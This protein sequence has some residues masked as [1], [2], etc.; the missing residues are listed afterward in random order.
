MVSYL[1]PLRLSALA[2]GAF[3]ALTACGAA[4]GSGEDD[5]G[6]A[7]DEAELRAL[8]PTEIVGPITP[9][10]TETVVHSGAPTYRGF[11]FS[12]KAG[13]NVEFW[14][15]SADGDA[16]A[17]LLRP[18]GSTL[19]RNDDASSNT[20]DA[21]LV[22]KIA[23]AGTYVLAF[24]EVKSRP[25]TF[26]VSFTG[27]APPPPPAAAAT[28]GNGI[29]EAGEICDDGNRN[30]QDGCT[31]YPALSDNE[32]GFER[33]TIA[34]A[35]EL[36]E[37]R[38]AS[39]KLY[40]SPAGADRD[41][42]TFTLSRRTKVRIDLIGESG[43]L[44]ID[45]SPSAPQMAE[46]T[47]TKIYDGQNNVIASNPYTQVNGYIHPEPDYTLDLDAGHYT[48]EIDPIYHCGNWGGGYYRLMVER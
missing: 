39:G 42:Y 24:R 21:H 9:G 6:V 34:A 10:A 40:E 35:T 41:Y 18:S 19:L 28:C 1:R 30:M 48:V 31:C 15:K 5:E 16:L 32:I 37:A 27:A 4:G 45:C 25:A 23:T 22:A 29:V 46:S 17:Y 33:T 12:A 43:H 7:I 44:S 47:M 38:L 2:L 26:T 36:G 20:S 11:T 14:V 13:D 8:K 3:V